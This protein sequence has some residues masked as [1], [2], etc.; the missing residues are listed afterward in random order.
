MATGRPRRCPTWRRD[1]VGTPTH[2]PARSPR[3][4]CA[5]RATSQAA[6]EWGSM[7]DADRAASMASTRSP[8][9]SA[10]RAS[11]SRARRRICSRLSRSASTQSSYQ[12]GSSSSPLSRVSRWDCS[13]SDSGIWENSAAR[14]TS[15]TSTSISGF[16]PDE[17][18]PAVQQAGTSV[19]G[20]HH[21][22]AQARERSLVG[23]VGPQDAGDV[24]TGPLTAQSQERD[25]P[26]FA[27]AE[28]QLGPVV[29]ELPASE[30][31][32]ADPALRCTSE[33]RHGE[34][35]PMPSPS[36]R[37]PTQATSRS[38]GGRGGNCSRQGASPHHHHIRVTV[39]RWSRPVA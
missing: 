6:S 3:A 33:L 19:L 39:A 29:D 7:S 25:Q 17:A 27:M 37:S 13:S 2:A 14:Q 34:P 32:Q 11:R 23:A 16:E 31:A 5:R 22:P 21:R 15:A 1:G 9:S 30:E 28:P 10:C 18:A 8:R 12:P 24:R 38:N 35:P 36:G 4:R 26:L 20:L